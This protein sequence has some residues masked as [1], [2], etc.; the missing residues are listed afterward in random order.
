[1]KNFTATVIWRVMF[2][3]EAS[4]EKNE[5]SQL[6]DAVISSI[7]RSLEQALSPLNLIFGPKFFKLGLRAVGRKHM[8]ESEFLKKTFYA[9]LEEMKV[10]L[11]EK[12]NGQVRPNEQRNLVE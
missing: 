4:F 10:K 5:I 6:I 8:R 11:I 3:Q 2:G 9:K 1:M 12:R 7:T